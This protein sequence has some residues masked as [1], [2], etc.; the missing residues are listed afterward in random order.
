M[1]SVD[2]DIRRQLTSAFDDT[3]TVPFSLRLPSTC[4]VTDVRAFIARPD[5][6]LT[7][8]LLRPL[9]Q[10]VEGR[11]EVIAAYTTH[12]LNKI[13]WTKVTRRSL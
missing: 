11:F 13:G 6:S 9:D 1:G 3:L 8:A 5:V 2:T 7:F 4:V 10:V 12:R